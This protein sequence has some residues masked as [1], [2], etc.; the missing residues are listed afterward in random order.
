MEPGTIGAKE[1]FVRSTSLDC[2]NQVAELADSGS[3]RVYVRIPRQL[4][5]YL[6]V[7]LPIVREAAKMGNDEVH[8]RIFRSKHVHH[9]R[10]ADDIDQD[11]KSEGP[12]R[13]TYLARGHAFKPMNFDSLETPARYGVLN[14]AEDFARIAFC[15]DKDKSNESL[16]ITSNDAGNLSVGLLIVAMKGRE[17]NRLVYPRRA[18]AAQMSCH[19]RIRVPRGGHFV[20]FSG[21]AVTVNNHRTHSLSS[22]ARGTGKFWRRKALAAAVRYQ[23]EVSMPR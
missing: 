16:G 20:A 5:R 11:R 17:H 8:I 10:T 23:T 7:R 3:I 9:L 14:H 15:V 4:I 22:T 6:L 18:G 19:R 2:F 21:V 12:R 1:K 13:F